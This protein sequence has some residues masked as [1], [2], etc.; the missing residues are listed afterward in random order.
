MTNT[1][2]LIAL[3][4]SGISGSSEAICFVKGWEAAISAASHTSHKIGDSMQ[5]NLIGNMIAKA[6]R[7]LKD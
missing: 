2:K 4:K 5:E 1:A 6:I 3:K 7:S